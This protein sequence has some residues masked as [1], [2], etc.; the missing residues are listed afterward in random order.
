MIRTPLCDLFD[1]EHPIALGGM[2]SASSPALTAAVSRAGPI[3][4]GPGTSPPLR[5]S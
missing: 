2:G 1:I 4:T 3:P 5:L